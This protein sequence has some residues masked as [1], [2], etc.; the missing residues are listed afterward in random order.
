MKNKNRNLKQERN[1]QFLHWELVKWEE[2]KREARKL[3]RGLMC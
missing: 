3:N 1:W 2:E